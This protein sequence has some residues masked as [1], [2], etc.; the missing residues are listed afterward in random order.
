MLWGLSTTINLIN[1]LRIL[2][3]KINSHWFSMIIKE[4]L[5]LSQTSDHH[6]NNE[7]NDLKMKIRDRVRRF[8]IKRSRK[9][10]AIGNLKDRLATSVKGSKQSRWLLA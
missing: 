6:Y 3:G 8:R 2:L 9:R 1:F 7:C 4:C 10:W 5:S